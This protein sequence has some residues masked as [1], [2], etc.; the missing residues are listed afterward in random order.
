MSDTDS[1][2]PVD[3]SK[4]SVVSALFTVRL[5]W[6]VPLDINREDWYVKYGT[7]Y[8]KDRQ[9]GDYKRYEPIAKAGDE[10]FNDLK[11]P[12]N[13]PEVVVFDPD[14]A[15]DGDEGRA[16]RS[17]VGQHGYSKE[18]EPCQLD[19]SNHMVQRFLGLRA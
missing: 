12:D 17:L 18:V 9:S 8:V 13:D 11:R 15:P 4:V 6:H 2:A 14:S 1:E 7:L 19:L 3:E 10:R 5:Q 16:N